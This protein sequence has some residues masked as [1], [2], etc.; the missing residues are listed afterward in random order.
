MKQN[1]DED[2]DSTPTYVPPTIPE[3]KPNFLQRLFG[4]KD[5]TVKKQE[6]FQVDTA[7]KT[8]KQIRQEKRAL[9][10]LEKA[11]QKELRDKGLL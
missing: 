4:K 6:E 7:G 1:N 11:R 10:K 5:T 2:D 9:K 3:K 8:K